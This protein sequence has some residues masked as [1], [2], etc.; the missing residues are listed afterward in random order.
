MQTATVNI[1]NGESSKLVGYRTID[2]ITNY[3]TSDTFLKI[4]TFI[5]D[6]KYKLLEIL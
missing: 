5:F 4:T 6:N 3:I 1:L 2:N